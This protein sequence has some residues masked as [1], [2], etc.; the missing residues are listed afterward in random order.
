MCPLEFWKKWQNHLPDLAKI[1]KKYQGVQES[2][3]ACERFST[4]YIIIVK[5]YFMRPNKIY[6]WCAFFY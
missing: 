5:K 4:N 6:I 3:A 1:A 2:S